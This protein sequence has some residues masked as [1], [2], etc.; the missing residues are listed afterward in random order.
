MTV[1]PQIAVWDDIL[2][3]PDIAALVTARGY[4]S[5]G[6]AESPDVQVVG[7]ARRS[8]SRSAGGSRWRRIGRARRPA[9][10]GIERTNGRRILGRGDRPTGRGRNHLEPEPL[11]ATAT[12]ADLDATAEFCGLDL[13]ARVDP[14]A[15]TASTLLRVR[16][17]AGVLLRSAAGRAS[18]DLADGSTLAV[19][20]LTH[21][22]KGRVV[23]LGITPDEQP[24]SIELLFNAL[25]YAAGHLRHR[26]TSHPVEQPPPIRPGSG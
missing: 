11:V 26:R 2:N 18:S 5:V 3:A 25:A 21:L 22:G 24:A 17:P 16:Q 9:G 12:V 23:V 20:A 8:P 10:N 14:G 19:A 1:F 13:L 4:G 7:P 6:P 15:L